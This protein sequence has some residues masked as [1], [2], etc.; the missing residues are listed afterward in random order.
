LIEN[1]VGGPQVASLLSR[2]V[3]AETPLA[4]SEI[5]KISRQFR[6]QLMEKKAS[7]GQAEVIRSK[8]FLTNIWALLAGLGLILGLFYFVLQSQGPKA[9]ATI[10]PVE[11]E[12]LAPIR[13]TISGMDF[14]ISA[15][16]VTIAQYAKF[17]QALE[18]LPETQRDLYDH[19][20]QPAQK[21]NHLP[22]DW[23]AM[24]RAAQNHAT[25]SELRMSLS[26]PVVAVDFWDAYAFCQWQEVRLPTAAEWSAAASQGIAPQGLSSYGDAMASQGDQTS[27]GLIGMAG[28]VSEWT[29]DLE[30]NPSFPLGA[31]QAVICGGSFEIPQILQKHYVENREIRRKDLGFRTVKSWP[32]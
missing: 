32:E 2:L 25:W 11:R 12:E 15:H 19:P 20:D 28:N 18:T 24:L 8:I 22:D 9:E 23:D 10:E 7:E 27:L 29:S 5:H 14:Q 1:R 6:E 31:Q 16:E 17:L 26:C 3:D 30:R 4:W 13:I 21:V